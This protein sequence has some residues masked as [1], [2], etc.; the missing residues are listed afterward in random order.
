MQNENQIIQIVSDKSGVDT[1]E[2]NLNSSLADDLGL[3][4]LDVLE[5]IMQMENVFNC[6]LREEDL[7]SE[8]TVQSLVDLLKK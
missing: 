6:S 1:S 4:S 5:I 7:D 8:Q 2:I 3:D